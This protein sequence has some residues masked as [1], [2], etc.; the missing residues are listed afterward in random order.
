[1]IT[2][3][4]LVMRAVKPGGVPG[5]TSQL[6]EFAASPKFSGKSSRNRDLEVI[7]PMIFPSFISGA[8]SQRTRAKKRV[9]NISRESGA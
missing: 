2:E 4:Q 5:T 6:R 9:L 1:V 8:I 3:F 7:S